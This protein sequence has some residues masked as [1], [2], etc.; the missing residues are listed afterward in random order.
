VIGILAKSTSCG[1]GY[2]R[3]TI[4]EHVLALPLLI[5]R[6]LRCPKR[7]L[8]EDADGHDRGDR[9]ARGHGSGTERLRRYE[10][11]V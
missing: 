10:L 7:T 3:G 11:E 2:R 8:A 5:R 6:L 1:D 4:Q 9:P